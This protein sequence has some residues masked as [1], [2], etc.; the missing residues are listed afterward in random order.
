M[1]IAA[2]LGASLRL[3][4]GPALERA[5]DLA[6][7]LSQPRRGRRAVHRRDPPDRTSGRG[8]AL[9]G[10]GGFPGRRRRGQG[11]G[12]HLDTPGGRTV[13]A[14]R[15]HHPLRCSHRSVARPVRVHRPHGLL[16]TRGVA[17]HP[18][19]FGGDSRV[20]TCTTTRAPRSPDARAAHR[21]SPT[22]CCAGCATTPRSGPT[23]S[24]TREIAR[25]ALEVYDV[26]PIGLD[27]LDRAVLGAL[28]RSFGG[29]PVG[30]STLA[31]AVGEEPGTVEE[32][33]E[34]FLV[35][36][37]MIARTPRGRV[38]TQAAW[39]QLGLTPPPG[40]GHR[41]HRGARTGAAA[42]SIRRGPGTTRGQHPARVVV[43]SAAR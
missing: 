8:D 1:I 25:A 27:R 18:A 14:R 28:V 32:V 40:G 29:G 39:L 37:G 43:G 16:R 34:P 23:V 35:R 36:A 38:A 7:M 15:C 22:G 42:R 9:P 30:V 2:E 31:V 33:C 24:S 13:H 3:T 11:A 12:C 17:A 6:A 26:D 19:A 20:S 41:R 10:D 21:V 4:S 5:G